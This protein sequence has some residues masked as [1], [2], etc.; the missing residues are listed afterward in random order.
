MNARTEEKKDNLF[1]EFTGKYALSKTL[2]F[3]LKPV[4]KTLENM[5]N[6]MYK[7]KK[8]YDPQLQTFLHD[9]DI[10]DA[11][12]TLK[13]VLDEI[14]EEFINDS[15]QSNSARGI[16]ISKYFD[17]YQ[18]K[19]DLKKME[20][21]LRRVFATSFT[22]T[23]NDWK[24]KKYKNYTWKKGNKATSGS[25][26][27]SSQDVLEVIR[28]K[29]EKNENIKNA[30]GVFKGFFTY[31]SGFNQNRAN[32]YE[33]KAEKATAVATRIV[34]EN[35][36]KF[37]DNVIFFENKESEYLNA[38]DF[39]K[40]IKE[41]NFILEIKDGETGTMKPLTEIRSDIF[42]IQHFNQCLSQSQIEKYNEEIGNAN[43][44]INLY[45][46]QRKNEKG[47]ELKYFKTLYKQIGCGKREALFFTLTHEKES[48]AEI[49][50]GKNNGSNKMF[51]SV[52]DVLRREKNAGEKYFSKSESEDGIQTIPDF[53]EYL[54]KQKEKGDFF[55]IYWS[56]S[57]MNTISNKYFLHW[58]SLLDKVKDK[59]TIATYDKNR[60][61]QIKMR[62][63][64]EL[65][66]FFEVLDKET[67]QDSWNKEGVFFR[68]SL[69]KMLPESEENKE[70]NAKINRRKSIIAQAKSPSDALLTMIFDDMEEYMR[71]FLSE[72]NIV[73]QIT[74]SYFLA[75]EEEKEEKKKLWKESIKQWL[76][77][78][79]SVSGM[80]KYFSVRGNKIKGASIDS[81]VSNALDILLDSDDA[82]WFRW[83]DAV[84]NFLTKKPQ[85]DAKE[86]KLKLNFENSSLAGGWD[87]NKES[88]N[89]CIILKDGG[90]RKYL[91]VMKKNNNKF[92]EKK[93]T[94]GRGKNKRVIKNPL[95]DENGE[96]LKMEYKQIAAP[97]GIGGFV[98][99]CFNTAQQYGWKCP[100]TCLNSEG[101]IITKNEEAKDV[102]KELIDCYKN[103]FDTY[104]KNGF[105]YK[106][107][108]FQF[109]PSSEYLNLNEL[110]SDV[111]NQGY[112]IS[113]INISK[114]ELDK[115]V[116]DGKVYLFEIKNQD[117]NSGKKIGH[118]LNLHTI[119]W[120]SVFGDN[121]EK[122]KLNGK[123]ELFYRPAT[124]METIKDKDGNEL[125]NKKGEKVLRNFRFSEEIFLFH[126]PITLNYKSKKYTE[127]KYATSEINKCINNNLLGR[128]MFLGIDRGEKHLAYYSL[129][130]REGNIKDQGTL[131]MPFVD[132]DGK[133][134]AI[135]VEK[136]MIGK[137]GKEKVKIVECHDY[138]EMLEARAGNRDYARKNWQTIG[139][140]KNLKE[141]YISQVV[142]KIVDLAVQNGAFIVLE[143][144]NVEFM[145][146]RQKIEKSV[147]QKLE[148]ALAKK[149]N[150]LVD[151]SA[152]EGEIGSVTKA[153]QLTPPVNTFGDMEHAKQFGIMLYTRAN[154]TS[155]TDPATGWRK[156]I[157]LQSG[158]N[159][160][161]YTK[162]GKIKN[163]S[164]RDQ[165]GEQFDDI[166]FENGHYFFAYTEK[167]SGKKW[168]LWSGHGGK[169][170]L[171]YRGK[172]GNNNEWITEEIKIE[173]NLDN[174]FA[175][176]QKREMSYWD[177][178]MSGEKELQ[179][180]KEEHIPWE[181]LRYHIDLIQQ[182]R[183]SGDANKGEPENFLLSPVRDENGNHFDSRDY[184][185][186][187]DSKFPKNADANG[188]YNIARKGI[189]M[190]AHIQTWIKN[191]SP[192]KDKNTSDLNLFVSEK[193]WDLWLKDREGWENMLSHFSSRKAMED[194]RK[195]RGN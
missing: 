172:R 190:N 48:E 167:N 53:I 137:D 65:S 3:E 67:E 145:R 35:L 26:I 143:D 56:K 29:N 70:E 118:R 192:K 141:G 175:Q 110:F 112:K 81:K 32:Y 72:R 139:N 119:Y 150:F 4:G 171:R 50:R 109:K 149:L 129:V 43:Y 47:K 23:A 17:I 80:L 68:E 63:A 106:D 148:L 113:F 51:I 94:E 193:E 20:E 85:D 194:E 102:L 152:K 98:R 27:L 146:G 186:L 52:E 8:D 54:R 41:K 76:D 93:W 168:R 61:K 131:N 31:F 90:N 163:K 156:T 183:N 105:K 161:T 123:A 1:S 180:I 44:V 120:N 36:P 142:R 59:K 40:N 154:Y 2:R 127:T 77:Y 49:S 24:E 178:L 173:E 66:A 6:R 22:E 130:D 16:E 147:Y 111:E 79:L 182:I 69:T 91:A 21:E 104:E 165:I 128:V 37:C 33:T 45:N 160:T 97:T 18:K 121:G 108:N 74:E 126:C 169:Q 46:Q 84:R 136:R 88:D 166:G 95:F 34:H 185:N 153:L 10:E 100:D 25:D 114:A 38:Y 9:Q 177:E 107:Y 19:E 96:W 195:K 122:P 12:Q 73:F 157:Y 124:K 170:L 14:H 158:P 134:R 64:I 92:F 132:K 42:R 159:E 11:Y 99:K 125:K 151:K 135:A 116:C 89:Y 71:M 58:D 83:Y 181:S 189:L 5:K 62:D 101:K 55:G 191:G 162:E 164:V 184:E 13:P 115:L 133:P 87:V 187:A 82:E 75:D 60:E 78:T 144:L 86:N 103:F 7:G 117:S 57:A 188:A 138:N 176:F 28:E 174:L 39:L 155:Q 30:L 140:I 179:K 15:L